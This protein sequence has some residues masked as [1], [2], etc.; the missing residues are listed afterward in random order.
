MSR[1]D[2]SGGDFRKRVTPT[3]YCEHMLHTITPLS[4]VPRAQLD[5]ITTLSEKLSVFALALSRPLRHETIALCCDHQQRGVGIFAFDSKLKLTQIIE[6]IIGA[7][8]S[9]DSATKICLLS[10]RQGAG[11]DATDASQ[12]FMAKNRCQDAGL[13]LTDWFLVAHGE[14]CI[15]Q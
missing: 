6:R 15:L 12:F 8:I 3:S 11:R 14:T 10:S 13:E 2:L 1:V 9:I 5:P 7:A 4:D